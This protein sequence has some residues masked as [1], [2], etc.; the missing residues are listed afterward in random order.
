MSEGAGTDGQRMFHG[1]LMNE[2]AYTRE[3]Y[4]AL[5][6]IVEV[7][8]RFPSHKVIDRVLCRRM[9]M[10]DEKRRKTSPVVVA[11]IIGIIFLL[12][13]KQSFFSQHPLEH[14][15]MDRLT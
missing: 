1:S 2:F 12:A 15:I 8:C 6:D 14:S 9:A 5:F 13:E 11:K 4:G 3:N 7:G 10:R